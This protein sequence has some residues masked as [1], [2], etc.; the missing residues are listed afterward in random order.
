[1]PLRRHPPLWGKPRCG[2]ALDM[3]NRHRCLPA[4]RLANPRRASCARVFYCRETPSRRQV[5]R[6]LPE[7]GARAPSGGTERILRSGGGAHN[8]TAGGHTLRRAAKTISGAA[9]RGVARCRCGDAPHST[10]WLLQGRRHSD[11]IAPKAAAEVA[12]GRIGQGS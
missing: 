1:M 2:A 8:K 12:A 4:Q 10:M 11:R 6:Q 7:W 5:R 9:G 3:R